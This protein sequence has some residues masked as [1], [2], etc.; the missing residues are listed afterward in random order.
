VFWKYGP[1]TATPAA[2]WYPMPAAISGNT[3]VVSITD[4]G[5]GDDDLLPNGSI[6]DPAGV[7]L[8]L[9]AGASIP[10]LGSPALAL[11]ALLLGAIALWSVRRRR[12]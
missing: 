3:V 6:T 7:G 10:T 4:G 11:L 2:H 5:L 12:R 8:L 1:T 9:G